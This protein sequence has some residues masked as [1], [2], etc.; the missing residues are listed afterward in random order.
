MRRGAT[1]IAML[2]GSTHHVD[3]DGNGFSLHG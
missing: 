2:G 1:G 3:H